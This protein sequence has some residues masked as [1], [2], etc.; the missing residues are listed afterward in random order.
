[1]G[2]NVCM[3]VCFLQASGER[4]NLTI[5][6][7]GKAQPGNPVREAASHSGSSQHHSQSL[8][9]SRPTSHKVRTFLVVVLFYSS[10]C[11]LLLQTSKIK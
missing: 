10:L 1:M 3:C 5:A 7:Q 11:G 9:P 4:V 6:R 8:Y 2:A